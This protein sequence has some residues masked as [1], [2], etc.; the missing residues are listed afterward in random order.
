LKR[1]TLR[2][3]IAAGFLFG[4]ALMTRPVMIHY[5]VILV[6]TLAVALT[7]HGKRTWPRAAALAFVPAILIL[8]FAAP[9]AIDHYRHYG[10]LSLT[11]QEGTHLLNWFYGC[12]AS[13]TPCAERGRVVEEMRP[14]SE[15]RAAALGKDKDNPF[16]VSAVERR[17]AIEK[18]LATPPAL[19]LTSMTAG[20]FRVLMQ[21]GFY[22]SF[23]QFRR[24]LTFFSAMPG[25]GMTERISNFISTNKTNVFMLLWVLAQTALVFSR[26]LQLAGLVHG[27]REP[28]YRGA[29]LILAATIIY[30]LVLTGP[31][32]SPKYRIP[33]EPPLLILFG[34][35][36]VWL[37]DRYAR[38]SPAQIRT[39]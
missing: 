27:L 9:R 6:P 8:A 24:P 29:A 36:W 11:A 30:F 16:A 38:P 19:I 20:M 26:G 14:I 37:R 4:L 1:N 12:L 5:L 39:A 13:P 2:L 17:L 23:A 10:Y 31:V 21:T 3:L 33:I 7:L 32:A 15:Q 35:G 22:E 34:M 18:I 25:T 28:A